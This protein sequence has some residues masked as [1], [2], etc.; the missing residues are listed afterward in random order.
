[1][2]LRLTTNYDHFV[3]ALYFSP[4]KG[5]RLWFLLFALLYR[6]TFNFMIIFLTYCVMSESFICRKYILQC[7]TIPNNIYALPLCSRRLWISAAGWAFSG[8]Q[9]APP[10]P[11]RV[12]AAPRR[13]G[14]RCR[15]PGGR[16]ASSPASTRCGPAA[17]ASVH[18]YKHSVW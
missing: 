7:K 2:C 9:A 15:P 18:T 5:I 13:T 12:G 8:R 17:Y 1:M 4:I 14:R 11:G 3:N 16:F 6:N 10:C